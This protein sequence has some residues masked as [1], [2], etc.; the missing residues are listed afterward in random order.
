MENKKKKTPIRVLPYRPGVGMMILNDRNQIF[1]GK[2]VE[3]KLQ[4][5]QMPQGGIDMGETPS[6]AAL[7]EMLEEIGSDNGTIIAESKNWYRYDIP[8]F[9][10]PKLWGGSYKGQSQKWFLIKFL[11]TDADININ[12][13]HPEFVDWRWAE[14]DELHDIIIPFKRKLYNAVIDE[15]RPLIK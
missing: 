9:L 5:W 15:F 3:A 4:A 11:G 1:L 2:R 12:T 6:K 7:R 14:L 8:K 13:S 10:I